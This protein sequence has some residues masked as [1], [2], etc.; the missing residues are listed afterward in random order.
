[1]IPEVVQESA[2]FADPLLQPSAIL[3]TELLRSFL[4][5]TAS[6]HRPIL[7]RFISR[8]MEAVVPFVGGTSPRIPRAAPFSTVG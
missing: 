4:R 6:D 8:R 1:M 3:C 2:V 7:S 5:R